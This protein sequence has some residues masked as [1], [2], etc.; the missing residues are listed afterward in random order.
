MGVFIAI[1]IIILS[2]IFIVYSIKKLVGKSKYNLVMTPVIDKVSFNPSVLII[3]TETTGLFI[4]N[5]IRATKKNLIEYPDNFPRLVQLCYMLMDEEGNYEGDVFYIKQEKNIPK[6][7]IK[8]HGITN[9]KC[10]NEGIE[11]EKGLEY[12]AIAASTVDS[13]VGHNIAF[14]YKIIQSESIRNNI[15]FSLKGMNKIDTMKLISK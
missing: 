12:L 1:A 13:I 3:D 10:N 6:Q 2:L 11:L 8:I 15:P 9:E 4:N 7:A 14:D 5:S